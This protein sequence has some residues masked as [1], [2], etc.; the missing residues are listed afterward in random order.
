MATTFQDMRDEVI[1]NTKRPELVSLTD[2]AIK[3]ATLR[4]HHVD[5]FPRDAT[6]YLLTY[7]VPVGNEL[8]TDIAN[9]YSVI[10]NFR[11]PDFM[12]GEELVTF[13]PNE[14]LEYVVDFKNF[15]DEYNSLRSSVFTLL[16]DTLRIKFVAPTGRARLFYYKNPV[17]TPVGYSSWIADLHKEELAKWAAAIVWARSGFQEIAATMKDTVT[18]FKVILTESYLSSKV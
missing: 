13:I 6:S 17:V 12:Q 8:W 4:A 1:A 2:S 15:W 16:G 5:F 14:N 18:D 10:T 9:I 3:M 11:A 7:A